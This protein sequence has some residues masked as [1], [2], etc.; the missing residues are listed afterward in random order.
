MLSSNST[1]PSVTAIM[2]ASWKQ[3]N[4]VKF[5]SLWK[6]LK[7]KKK[8]NKLIHLNMSRFKY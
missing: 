5:E 3:A 2:V 7:K 6:G 1:G 8:K 4:S